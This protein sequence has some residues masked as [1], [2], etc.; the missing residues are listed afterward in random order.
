VRLRVG[1]STSIASLNREGDFAPLLERKGL[2][3]G[4]HDAMVTREMGSVEREWAG[5][6]A[7]A[8]YLGGSP[9]D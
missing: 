3:K 1:P 6:D 5:C 4:A 2:E 8:N 7:T 9:R